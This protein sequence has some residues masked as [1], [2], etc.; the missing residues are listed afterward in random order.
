MNTLLVALCALVQDAP[1]MPKP[2]KEHA[3]LKALE[4]QWVTETEAKPDAQQPPMTFKGTSTGR[5]LGGFW[6]QLEHQAEIMGM[7]WTGVMQLGFDP[8]SK[9]YIGTWVDSFNAHQWKLEG[10]VSGQVLTLDTEGPCCKTGKIEKFRE[11]FE[12][13]GKDALLFT[14]SKLENGAWTPM[15]KVRYA[16]KLS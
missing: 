1:S 16:R 7:P 12:V 15:L 11:T 5:S 9:K 3:W 13:Q 2:E 10:T 6:L 14:S 4:G 8:A